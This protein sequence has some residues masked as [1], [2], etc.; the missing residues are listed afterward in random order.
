MEAHSKKL[1]QD[2]MGKPR[3]RAHEIIFWKN[4]PRKEAT[5]ESI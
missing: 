5:T 2:E 3:V 1:K 4:S